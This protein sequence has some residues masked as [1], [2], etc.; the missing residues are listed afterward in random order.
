[1]RFGYNEKTLRIYVKKQWLR[2]D[3]DADGNPVITESAMRTFKAGLCTGINARTKHMAPARF[4]AR[5]FGAVKVK[6]R[7]PKRLPR[8]LRRARVAERRS[9]MV[10]RRSSATPW[11]SM[12]RPHK[13]A[14]ALPCTLRPVR[15]AYP[16]RELVPLC[17][18]RA[19]VLNADS[20]TLP[21]LRGTGPPGTRPMLR[22]GP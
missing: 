21:L 17:L 6:R 8:R 11:A 15:S 7:E 19:E 20:A 3:T 1:M 13:S 9:C 2:A 14:A 16:L 5:G 4:S 18:R 12:A 22:A 10:A